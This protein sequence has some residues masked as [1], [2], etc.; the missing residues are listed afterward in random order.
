MFM[1][2][3]AIPFRDFMSESYKKKEMQIQKYHAWSPL[4]FLHMSDAIVNTYL[5][6]G[7]TG[8]VLIGGVLLEKYLVQND[9]IAAAK[10]CS[11]VM[12]YGVKLGGVGFIAYIFIRIVIMF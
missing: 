3:Q 2:K 6:L 11:D 8:G 9:S 7:V 1:K 4:A 10:L 12:Y 5:A